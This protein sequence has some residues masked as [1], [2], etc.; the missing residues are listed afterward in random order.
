MVKG[1]IYIVGAGPGRTDLITVRGLNILKEAEVIIYDY[2]VGDGLLK[3]ANP[4]AEKICADELG[5]KRYANSFTSAQE[6]INQ[7]MIKKVLQG[8]KVVRLKNGDP[9]IFGRLSQEL[10]ALTNKKI[11]FEVVPG[12]TAASVAAAYVGIP[13]TDRRFA[14]SVVLATGHEDP[15]KTKSLLDWNEIASKGTIVLYMAVENLPQITFELI[16]RGKSEKTPALII[17]QA[18]SLNQ[19]VVRGELKSIAPK[20]KQAKLSAPAVVIIGE[21]AK[22]EKHFN[23]L[24]KSKRILFTG[25]SSEH[26]FEKGKTY[27]HLPLIEIK[28]LEDYKE[29]DQHLPELKKFDWIVFSSRFGVEYFF[30]RLIATGKDV[31]ALMEVKIAAVGNSTGEKL[32]TYGLRADL[33]PKEESSAGLIKEFKKIGI[34]GKKVF[35]PRSD[36]ADKGLAKGLEKLGAKVTAAVAYQNVMPKNLPDLDFDF[37]DEIYFTSPSTVRNF[38][39]RYGKVPKKIK[40]RWIGKVTKQAL[41]KQGML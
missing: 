32:L 10:E 41:K 12:V 24:K 39:K 25:L 20:V 37:F 2:L 9:S 16:R 23:W 29:F 7:L 3:L 28:P 22:L 31:R 21:V 4:Q 13:L 36:L 5:K 19:K 18:G 35:L 8:K 17:S 26:F 14:S 40:V 15:N 11:E 6:K 34:K 30:E 27:F 1:K 38:K 33:I